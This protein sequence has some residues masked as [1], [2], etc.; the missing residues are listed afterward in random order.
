M[1]YMKRIILL[2][3]LLIS[4]SNIYSQVLE[5]NFDNADE[6]V[7]DLSEFQFEIFPIETNMDCIIGQFS[8]IRLFDNK[9]YISDYT[10]HKVLVFKKNGQYLF[11]IDAR[12]NGPKE[13]LSNNSFTINPFNKNIEI[14]DGYGNTIVKFDARGKFVSKDKIPFPFSSFE[15]ITS[16]LLAFSKTYQPTKEKVDYNLFLTTTDYKI[17]K[18][19]SRMDNKTSSALTFAPYFNLKK[20]KDKIVW[21]KAYDESIYKVSEKGIETIVELNFG[22]LWP[23]KE[24]VFDDQ[25]NNF[26]V[27]METFNKKGWLRYFDIYE[28][29]NGYLATFFAKDNNYLAVFNKETAKSC[30]YNCNKMPDGFNSIVGYGDD[31]V[32]ITMN[33]KDVLKY[34]FPIADKQK[35]II[36]NLQEDDNPCIVTIRN[37]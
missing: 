6:K 37:K 1:K 35:E 18:R 14:V 10:T 31:Y 2:Y 13:Y 20:Y 29:K 22:N 16:D 25:I 24:F 23:D 21:M 34:N 27:I 17:V 19:C 36:K 9:W 12:G 30:F 5:L 8:Q 3:I 33:P 28:M 26:Q 7:F 15:Y 11:S 32:I 4:V